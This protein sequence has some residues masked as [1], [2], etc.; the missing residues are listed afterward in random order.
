MR[1]QN[2]GSKY[3]FDSWLKV[4]DDAE[5]ARRAYN[6]YMRD[7]MRR[8]RLGRMSKDFRSDQRKDSILE[9]GIR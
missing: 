6:G 2:S 8:Y 3:W 7:Y 4:A 1:R 5:G 9:G